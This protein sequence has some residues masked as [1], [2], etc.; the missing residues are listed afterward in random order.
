MPSG[1]GL[2]PSVVE[3]LHWGRSLGDHKPRQGR[4]TRRRRRPRDAAVPA[5]RHPAAFESEPNRA[6]RGDGDDGN[7][8]GWYNSGRSGHHPVAA[9]RP[10]PPCAANG[11]DGGDGD[12]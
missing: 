12:C 10:N 7:G 6:V 9:F 11:G 1:S 3:H 4:Q 8:P 5:Q 2:G